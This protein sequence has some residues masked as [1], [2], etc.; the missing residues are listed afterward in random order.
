MGTG[1]AAPGRSGGRGRAAWRLGAVAAVA[2]ASVLL[3]PG[4][5]QVAWQGLQASWDGP[6][7]Q[8]AAGLALF[9]LAAPLAA[10]EVIGAR[11]PAAASLPVRAAVP[12]LV[13]AGAVGWWR[14]WW[15]LS[16][17]TITGRPRLPA[18]T[19]LEVVAMPWAVPAEGRALR[20]AA[21]V[22]VLAGTVLVL[23]G[24]AQAMAPEAVDALRLG[25][26]MWATTDEWR[27]A[28]ALLVVGLSA[29]PIIA[30][31]PASAFLWACPAAAVPA[32]LLTAIACVWAR[33]PLLRR[34]ARRYGGGAAGHGALSAAQA[35]W[36]L[37]MRR[38]RLRGLHTWLW[39]GEE[40]AA[41][42]DRLA[43]AALETQGGRT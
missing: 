37:R 4:A 27:P 14:L 24:S 22:T 28:L 25:P 17:W 36:W 6:A 31:L 19:L 29:A 39:G 35:R 34:W 18:G 7:L 9:F 21:G 12:L 42:I 2:A 10:G 30:T 3:G 38:S 32:L 41:V 20:A 33:R 5:S 40:V 1:G 8:R 26:A 15:R 13:W 11:L 16:H 43:V 23:A